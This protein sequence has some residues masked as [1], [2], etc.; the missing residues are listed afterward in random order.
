MTIS[1]LKATQKWA[2]LATSSPTSGSSVTFSSLTEY[3]NYKVS[4]FNANSSA[5]ATLTLTL[6]NDTTSSYSWIAHKDS[7]TVSSDGL[8][9]SIRL[10]DLGSGG[11][12]TAGSGVITILD[13][14]QLIKN[15]SYF[16]SGN[17]DAN[18]GQGYWND[19][20]VINRIDFTLSGG[21]TFTG[22]TIKVYGRN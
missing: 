16:H 8:D 19:Q 22:G 4:Y 21:A 1:N 7:G 17:E 14:N 5:G 18:N 10:G 3:S 20:S 9:T 11:S 6:N 15:I 13:A 12:A 2:E